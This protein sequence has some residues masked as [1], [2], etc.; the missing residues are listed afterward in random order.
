MAVYTL[1]SFL[2]AFVLIIG[3][4][5]LAIVRAWNEGLTPQGVLWGSA[6]GVW[7]GLLL[8]AV[9]RDRETRG[10]ITFL[11]GGW[12]LLIPDLVRTPRR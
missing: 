11:L 3:L 6:A 5:A 9:I 2:L 7:L 10:W 4:P 12:V 8:T 1:A